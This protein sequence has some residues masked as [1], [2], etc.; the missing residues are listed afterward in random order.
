MNSAESTPSIE[1][2]RWTFTVSAEN[3]VEIETHLLDLGLEIPGTR[4]DLVTRWR[5]GVEELI[6]E[7]DVSSER[8]ISR[9]P[10]GMVYHPEEAGGEESARGLK[11]VRSAMP[12][13]RRSDAPANRHTV[14]ERSNSGAIGSP[15]QSRIGRSRRSRTRSRGRRRGSDRSWRRGRP[16]CTPGRPDTPRSGPDWPI[17]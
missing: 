14:R 5:G 6:E 10:H 3:R 4:R 11:H 1:L 16:A 15:L 8:E 17:T 9:V 13:P 12:A 7:L 2:I